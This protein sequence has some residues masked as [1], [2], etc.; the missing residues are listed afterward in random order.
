L[1]SPRR[2]SPLGTW[3]R[4]VLAVCATTLLSCAASHSHAALG[5]QD[6]LLV[7]NARVPASRA[8]ADLYAKQ[9][10]IPEGRIVEISVPTWLNDPPEEIAFDAYDAQVAQPVRDFLLRQHLADRVK[11]VVTFWGV[12]LKIGRRR[13][14]PAETA[15]RD[16]L[17]RQL[18][19]E[20][21]AISAQIAALE[22][23]ASDFDPTFKAVT[24]TDLPSL[25]A[26]LQ[27]ALNVDFRALSTVIDPAKRE[28][29]AAKLVTAVEALLGKVRATQILAQPASA[30]VLPHP[31]TPAATAAA[32][33]AFIRA[34]REMTDAQ[35]YVADPARRKHVVALA[36]EWG[37]PMGAASLL[38][39]QVDSFQVEE[40]DSA[41][42]NELALLWWHA[43]PRARWLNN[44]L[45]W[46]ALGQQRNTQQPTLM[47]TR[48]DGPTEMA[49][50][51]LI[52]TSIEVEQKG[53][54]GQVVLDARGKPPT[55]GYGQYDETIRALDGL[56]RAHTSLPVTFDNQEPIIPFHS[57]K[58]PIA[59]YCGWY[60]LRKYTP[61]GHF[62]PGAV[63]FHVASFEM[64]SLHV[65]NEAGWARGL[66]SDGLCATL[67]PVAEPYLL[68]FPPANEF[69]PLLLTGKLTTAEVYWRTMPMVSWMQACV[70]DPLYTP[71]KNNPPLKVEDLP[72]PLRTAIDPTSAATTSRPVR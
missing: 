59:L 30:R 22:K 17:K 56:L 54:T 11:C 51:R 33:D 25:N 5:P 42:D 39:A 18:D 61:P 37:G 23:S 40:S 50:R 69:F 36:R 21:A 68:S 9:R 1:G 29:Q 15:E 14:T 28:A 2:Q 34:D 8:L 63:G 52:T 67:G 48:L 47:V 16:D 72:T 41:L 66:L 53:L 57:V 3:T 70:A 65:H 71:F 31:P 45:Q 19:Q 58:E 60:S 24:A 12:P 43:Y 20:S 4:L 46:R 62:A 13:L 49:V 26:R 38:A 6:I 10:H 55:D 27:A 35:G 44:P 32:R 7:V 64:V